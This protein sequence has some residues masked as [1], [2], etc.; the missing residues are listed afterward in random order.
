VDVDLTRT[1]SK[2][3]RKCGVLSQVRFQT[4]TEMERDRAE[5][6]SGSLSLVCY[7][8]ACG[9]GCERSTGRVASL[10]TRTKRCSDYVGWWDE[11]SLCVLLTDTDLTGAWVCA[12]RS[13]EACKRM[14]VHVP[15]SVYTFPQRWFNTADA[16][17]LS[18]R[19]GEAAQVELEV[20][21][22]VRSVEA[23][24]V[25]EPERAA[26]GAGA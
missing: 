17:P 4:I 7:S 10:L 11:Q 24:R 2:C 19:L 18:A 6:Y 12:L 22:A 26:A 15:F 5:R 16:T 25:R 20:V 1:E 13:V 21:A 8:L 14:G 23:A 9:A 3:E